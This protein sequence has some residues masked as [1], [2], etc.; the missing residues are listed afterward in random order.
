MTKLTERV[1]TIIQEELYPE[2]YTDSMPLPAVQE[3]L[4]M[5]MYQGFDVTANLEKV[6]QASSNKITL[7]SLADRQN[8]NR[9]LDTIQPNST[10]KFDAQ[11][12]SIRNK[13]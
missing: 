8:I 1:L 4:E 10:A 11:F 9:M 12:E 3:C 2:I 7:L 13:I 6:N 5:A